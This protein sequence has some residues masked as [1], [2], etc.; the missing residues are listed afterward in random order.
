MRRMFPQPYIS[1]VVQSLRR[2]VAIA[3]IVAACLAIVGQKAFAQTTGTS[4]SPLSVRIMDASGAILPAGSRFDAKNDLQT[5]LILGQ[6]TVGPYRLSWRNAVQGSEMVVVDGRL[7]QA[8]RDYT[9]DWSS[10]GI[11]CS[12]PVPSGELARVTYSANTPTTVPANS[13]TYVPVS[14][15]LWQSY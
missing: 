5:D 6:N 13:G 12:V 9:I 11:R 15:N 1:P 14:L 8:G 7:L 10:G 4:T 2:T 3:L